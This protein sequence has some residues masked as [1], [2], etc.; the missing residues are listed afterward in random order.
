MRPQRRAKSPH[1]LRVDVCTL[2]DAVAV[3]S[4][5]IVQCRTAL[6]RTFQRASDAP[7]LARTMHHTQLHRLTNVVLAVLHGDVVVRYDVVGSKPQHREPREP[8][9][10]C[11]RTVVGAAVRQR[12][13]QDRAR[14]T[15]SAGSG[16]GRCGSSAYTG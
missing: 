14:A 3:A 5:F 11:L 9:R 10:A 16:C 13:G 7:T 12:A 4:R 6:K 2:G 15:G 1:P 8:I